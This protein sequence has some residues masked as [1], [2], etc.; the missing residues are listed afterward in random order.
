MTCFLVPVIYCDGFWNLV[1]LTLEKERMCFYFIFKKSTIPTS[2]PNQNQPSSRWSDRFEMETCRI[3]FT[4]EKMKKIVF[5]NLCRV[6]FRRIRFTWSSKTLGVYGN[7]LCYWFVWCL[8][9][10]LACFRYILNILSSN[11]PVLEFLL[12]SFLYARTSW[13]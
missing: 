12:T 7:K 1:W 9:I 6:W 3:S 4:F 13:R 11:H 5:T 10:M 8:F 2:S